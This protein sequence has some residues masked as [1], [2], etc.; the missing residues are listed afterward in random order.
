MLGRWFRRTVL[1]RRWA[2]FIVLGLSFLLFGGGTVNLLYTLHANIELIA[3]HGLL[4]LMEG[5]AWQLLEILFTA[6]L[7]MAAYVVFKTCEHRLV[8][9]LTDLEKPAP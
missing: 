1:A 4:A 9:S 5:A 8:H 6:Y 3:V 2:T 7:S